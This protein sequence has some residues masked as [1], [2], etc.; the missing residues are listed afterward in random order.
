L[1]RNPIRRRLDNS[2]RFVPG[3]LPLS[4]FEAI[5]SAFDRSIATSQTAA[6]LKPGSRKLDAISNRARFSPFAGF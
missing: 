5:V 4:I 3:D 2:K 1:I 6:C